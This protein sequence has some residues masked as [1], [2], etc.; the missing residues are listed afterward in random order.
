MRMGP[1]VARRFSDRGGRAGLGTDLSSYARA[2]ILVQA[3]LLLQV[4]RMSDEDPDP[5]E[6]W[7]A[8]PVLELA[9]RQAADSLGLGSEVGSLT[10]GKRANVVRECGDCAA[11]LARCDPLGRSRCLAAVLHLPR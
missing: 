3:R 7:P 6:I 5:K 2:D 4:E 10:A 11:C 9:T 8:R 1:L